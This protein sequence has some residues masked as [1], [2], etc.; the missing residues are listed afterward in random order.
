MPTGTRWCKYCS[1]ARAFPAQWSVLRTGKHGERCGQCYESF[2]A[3]RGIGNDEG[4][5]VQC[6]PPPVQQQVQ[7]QRLPQQALQQQ[8]HR[9]ALQQP[10]RALQPQQQ[11][12]MH[13]LASAQGV[14]QDNRAA[15]LVA[16]TALIVFIVI[17]VLP[18]YTKGCEVV[19][20]QPITVTVSAHTAG[21]TREAGVEGM[22]VVVEA[23]T[24]VL[25]G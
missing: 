16:M 25:R 5:E 17:R 4:A 1:T 3:T 7:Q 10:R 12:R 6:P 20:G 18:S 23:S 2:L 9:Q 11:R 13:Y 19:E 22:V 14:M 21:S 15:I 8:G 24:T